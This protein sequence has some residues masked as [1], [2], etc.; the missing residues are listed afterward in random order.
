MTLA[1]TVRAQSA[2]IRADLE[3]LVAVPSVSADR[4]RAG[5]VQRS[6]DAVAALLREAG[7]PEVQ[8]VRADGGQPAVIARFPAPEGRP[9]VCLYAH[10]DVQPPGVM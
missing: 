10:H 5:E 3:A 9:T 8:V 4:A 2:R 7:C 6:A 1:E